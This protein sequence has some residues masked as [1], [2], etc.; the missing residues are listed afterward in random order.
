MP[1]TSTPLKCLPLCWSLGGKYTMC[2]MQ[3]DDPKHDIKTFFSKWLQEV[4]LQTGD[5]EKWTLC[6]FLFPE[7]IY[8][9]LT[10]FALW[11][12]KENLE[13]RPLYLNDVTWLACYDSS[14]LH[15]A[16]L[17]VHSFSPTPQHVA[18]RHLSNM[19]YRAAGSR[20]GS[21]GQKALEGNIFSCQHLMDPKKIHLPLLLFNQS[22]WFF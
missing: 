7:K 10:P 12:K 20:G 15:L 6:D 22:N 8:N 14:P 18:S 21:C 17:L 2:Y 13:H 9:K 4:P 3:R 1:I 5:N 16:W 11:E 19:W